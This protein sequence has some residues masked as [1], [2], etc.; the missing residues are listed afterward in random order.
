VP[1]GEVERTAWIEVAVEGTD[2]RLPLRCATDHLE[3]NA[4]LA[5][6]SEKLPGSTQLVYEL[7]APQ[8]PVLR[9]NAIRPARHLTSA[10]GRFPSFGSAARIP[11]G[12]A[13]FA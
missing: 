4:K 10:L 6:A 2:P 9:R 8:R 1:A 11:Y 5:P 12:S 7:G 3:G 13:G